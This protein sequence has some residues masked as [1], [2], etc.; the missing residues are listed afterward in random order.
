MYINVLLSTFVIDLPKLADGFQT[1]IDEFPKMFDEIDTFP[2]VVDEFQ[3]TTYAYLC[4][5]SAAFA[6]IPSTLLM[7]LRPR[8]VP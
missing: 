8:L 1:L 6:G 2:K 5:L 7:F 3:K 4:I